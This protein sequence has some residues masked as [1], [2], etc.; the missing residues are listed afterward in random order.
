MTIDS[1]YLSIRSNKSKHPT[2][3][4]PSEKSLQSMNGN[5]AQNC[6]FKMRTK[7]KLINIAEELSTINQL[8]IIL[9]II[10]KNIRT[11]ELSGALFSTPFFSNAAELLFIE[12]SK[13]K[14]R[15][16]QI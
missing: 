4:Q 1:I 6:P 8:K 14:S 2:Q 10:N 11:P 12:C 15:I 9:K 7:E 3:E 5:F 16:F 13:N